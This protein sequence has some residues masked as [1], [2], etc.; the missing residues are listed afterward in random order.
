L[1]P[2]KT[3]AKHYSLSRLT[4]L[5]LIVD[6]GGEYKGEAESGTKIETLNI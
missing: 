1:P 6:T 3:A 2:E 5:S 4:E